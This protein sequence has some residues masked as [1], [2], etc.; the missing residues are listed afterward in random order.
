[1]TAIRAF[2]QKHHSLAM[3]V[4]MLAMAV[5]ALVPTGFMLGAE[6]GALTIKVC[7]GIDHGAAT[8]A[9]P[10]KAPKGADKA[11]HDQQACPFSALGHAGQAGADPIQIALALAFILLLGLAPPRTPTRIAAPRLRPPL[12]APP[13]L[14]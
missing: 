14:I 3:A 5:K 11:G 9:I 1:M 6:A 8:I 2:F 13:A 10:V 4:L 12:R 7:D